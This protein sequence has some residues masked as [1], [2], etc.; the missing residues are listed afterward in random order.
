VLY[1]YYSLPCFIGT[2]GLL[3][4]AMSPFP[5]CVPSSRQAYFAEQF[6]VILVRCV[7][8]T[9]N[10]EL[11]GICL[12]LPLFSDGLHQDQDFAISVRVRRAN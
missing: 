3:I 2:I 12:Y 11:I 8:R 9:H 4:R 1:L 5:I 6:P 7:Y 10:V